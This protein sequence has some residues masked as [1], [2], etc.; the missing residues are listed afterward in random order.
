MKGDTVFAVYEE[1]G[2]KVRGF[3]YSNGETTFCNIRATNG[4]CRGVNPVFYRITP[5]R[6]HLVER[7]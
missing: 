3:V 4:Q 7:L 2:R 5:C 1:E 6:I